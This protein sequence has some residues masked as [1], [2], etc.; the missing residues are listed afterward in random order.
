[1][2]RA[3]RHCFPLLIALVLCGT[4]WGMSAQDSLWVRGGLTL[5][6]SM[7]A[8]VEWRIGGLEPGEGSDTTWTRILRADGLLAWA[9]TDSG[10]VQLDACWPVWADSAEYQLLVDSSGLS[11]A[12]FQDTLHAP[13]AALQAGCFP[14]TPAREVDRALQSLEDIP[15]ESKRHDAAVLWMRRHCLAIRDLRRIA[16]RFDD[17][18]RRMSLLQGAR[19][20][21]M[22]CPPWATSSAP[23]TRPNISNG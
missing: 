9:K 13:W 20:S 19:P 7:A 23:A 16:N 5:V 10:Q 4:G 15:F 8:D 18:A 11:L 14:A 3:F 1:M 6:D 17:D 22:S 21:P 12:P 2:C